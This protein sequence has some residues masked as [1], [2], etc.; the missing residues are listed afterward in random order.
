MAGKTNLITSFVRR[1]G[2]IFNSTTTSWYRP[3]AAQPGTN[4]I[5]NP[6]VFTPET[7]Y[8]GEEITDLSLGRLYT[9]DGAEIVEPNAPKAILEGLK[10]KKPDAGVAGSPL[11]LTVESGNARI[12]GK[13]YWHEASAAL[14]D[15]ILSPN[16]N[17]SKGRYDIITIK[18]DY[19]NPATN[20]GVPSTEYRGS[21]QVY[22]GNVYPIG[23]PLTFL[24]NTDTGSPSY[25]SYAGGTGAVT[26]FTIGDTV[27]G[28]GVPS[29]ATVTAINSTYI[30]ISQ[31]VTGTN[32]GQLYGVAIDAYQVQKGFFATVAAGST[33]V[34]GIYPQ[35]P[36]LV[37]GAIVVGPGI[38]LGTT[39]TSVGVGTAAL[40]APSTLTT[41]DFFAVGDAADYL[42]NA[43][44][45]IPDDEIIL[46]IVFVPASYG[47]L[48]AHKLRPLSVS[49]FG[50]HLN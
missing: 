45:T 16:P 37:A 48:S 38:P 39:L 34:T 35:L 32:T 36:T 46:G 26:G 9:Q 5:D 3:T 7:I 21:L 28:P 22:T 27:V 44:L 24:G 17:P 25:I 33:A 13:T 12:N 14:G 41:T 18:S 20:T 30:E 43:P 8:K 50:L 49:D 10:V 31:S 1:I 47:V 2:K 11:W 19:P 42:L 4:H 6:S 15:V 29:G 40:S 23:R